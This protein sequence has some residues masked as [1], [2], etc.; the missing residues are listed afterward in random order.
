MYMVLYFL[1]DPSAYVEDRLETETI[2]EILELKGGGVGSQQT[3]IFCDSRAGT[4]TTETYVKGEA[5]DGSGWMGREGESKAV[6]SCFVRHDTNS[7]PQ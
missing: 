3:P 6:G 1:G 4:A 2:C 7:K 5:S